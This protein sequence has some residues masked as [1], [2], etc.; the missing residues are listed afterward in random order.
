M[1]PKGA[2]VAAEQGKEGLGV[3][4]ADFSPVGQGC[5]VGY[6]EQH[7]QLVPTVLSPAPDRVGD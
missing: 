7:S 6:Q 5:E 4:G 1:S 2:C 3:C